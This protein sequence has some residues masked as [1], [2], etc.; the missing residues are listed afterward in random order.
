MIKNQLQHKYRERSLSIQPRTG[1]R[2]KATLMKKR[3]RW[4]AAAAIVGGV[5]ASS[6]NSPV[7]ADTFYPLPAAPIVT[8][9]SFP[10]GGTAIAPGGDTIYTVRATVAVDA[11][12]KDLSTVTMCLYK[13]GTA[14]TFDTVQSAIA[15]GTDACTGAGNTAANSFLVTWTALNQQ[16]A[17]S[18]TTNGL[19]SW[20]L[21]TGGDVS[22]FK[23]KANIGDASFG[24]YTGTHQALQIEF[25]FKVS[26]AM[27]AGTDWKV[28]TTA[29]YP[30]S[31]C[32][33]LLPQDPEKKCSDY[34]ASIQ[35]SG[36]DTE[37]IGTVAYYSV[38]TTSAADSQ[39]LKYGFLLPGGTSLVKESTA[40]SYIANTISTM[41]VVGTDFT[42]TPT[43]KLTLVTT[44]PTTNKEVRIECRDGRTGTDSSTFYAVPKETTASLV[45]QRDVT[46]ESAD[47]GVLQC[48]LTYGGGA[49]TALVEY[50]NTVT[51]GLARVGS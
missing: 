6:P 7:Q 20:Q 13:D 18:S 41:T 31:L 36:S 39:R 33:T 44:V 22:T 42:A 11:Q 3:F 46:D 14:G 1:T 12:V 21:G 2:Q 48:K 47:T 9:V 35:L 50:S 26:H 45:V 49:K 28:K 8:N 24:E 15:T 23:T 40:I 27:L 29:T 51:V 17:I 32:Q 5:V 16:F 10:T 4:I 19:A 43:D 34:D 25:K 37:P 30:D 38:V